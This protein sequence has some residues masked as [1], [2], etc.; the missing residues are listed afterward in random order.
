M[1]TAP[2]KPRVTA[3]GL[4]RIKTCPTRAATGERSAD[5]QQ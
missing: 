3:H 5:D 1:S 2:G 4:L